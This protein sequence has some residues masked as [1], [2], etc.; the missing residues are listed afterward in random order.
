MSSPSIPPTSP[1]CRLPRVRSRL[2]RCY[3]LAW[4]GVMRAPEWTMIHGYLD[5]DGVAVGHAWLAHD[6]QVFCPTSDRLFTQAEYEAEMK[7]VI[8]ATYSQ[9]Q[10][11][12]EAIAHRHYGP[13]C[14]DE[15]LIFSRD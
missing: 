15:G 9:K 3:E 7:P 1:T 4:H 5:C 14:C 8:L 6:G 11:A 10:A 13:W 12:A 2:H